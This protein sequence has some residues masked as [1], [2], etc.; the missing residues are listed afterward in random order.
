MIDEVITIRF[1]PLEPL[2]NVA[3]IFEEHCSAYHG[4]YPLSVTDPIDIVNGL[5]AYPSQLQLSCCEPPL[6]AA[7]TY[8]DPLPPRP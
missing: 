7:H 6:P 1:C 8:I 4:K 3:A 5:T 2:L